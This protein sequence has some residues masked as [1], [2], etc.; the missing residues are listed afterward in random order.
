MLGSKI[1]IYLNISIPWDFCHYFLLWSEQNDALE[2]Y[3]IGF[4]LYSVFAY[5][6]GSVSTSDGEQCSVFKPV[7]CTSSDIRVLRNIWT[8]ALYEKG[9]IKLKR[10]SSLH[11]KMSGT[12]DIFRI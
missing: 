9:L 5:I 3:C 6:F 10:I 1:Y 7:Y 11:L 4:F 8:K 12:F 2:N